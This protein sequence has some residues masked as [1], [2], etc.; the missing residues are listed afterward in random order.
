MNKLCHILVSFGI[1]KIRL[2]LYRNY[3]AF[4]PQKKLSFSDSE[5]H[6]HSAPQSL[7]TTH[8]R[9]VNL[10]LS[11]CNKSSSTLLLDSIVY[12]VTANCLTGHTVSTDK[13]YQVPGLTAPGL[14]AILLGLCEPA[15]APLRGVIR[16]STGTLNLAQRMKISQYEYTMKPELIST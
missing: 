2:V 15:L 16:I 6:R 12:S 5:N 10:L 13:S 9:I 3:Y 4:G 11:P 8:R 1:A 7:P 14:L